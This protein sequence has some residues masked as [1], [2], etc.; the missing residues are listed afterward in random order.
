MYILN[1]YVPPTSLSRMHMHTPM[2]CWIRF[3]VCWMGPRKLVWMSITGTCHW[4]LQELSYLKRDFS[5]FK[6][7]KPHEW[8]YVISSLVLQCDL[9]PLNQKFIYWVGWALELKRRLSTCI[10]IWI[11]RLDFVKGL[12]SWLVSS[13]FWTPPPPQT[14]PKKEK[15]QGETCEYNMQLEGKE[16]YFW[17][18]PN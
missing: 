5:K 15:K 12:R 2:N 10:S 8:K 11:L 16:F 9:S 1:A 14:K 3:L 4:L 13:K 17:S 18:V 7:K 6:H